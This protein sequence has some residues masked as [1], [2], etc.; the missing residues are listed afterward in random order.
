MNG[1]IQQ[2]LLKNFAYFSLL[3]PLHDVFI[4]QLLSRELEYVPLAHSCNIQ[5]PWCKKCP[6]CAYIWLNYM[7]YLPEKLVNQIFDN[8]NLL[9]LPENQLHFQQLLGFGSHSPF[10]CIGQVEESQLAL[11]RCYL[12]GVRGNAMKWY[13]ELYE[14]DFDQIV[15]KFT[16]VATHV[17]IPKK[18]ADI[19]YPYLFEI[20][21]ITQ[22]E[23]QTRIEI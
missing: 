8:V 23:L 11:H 21:Q 5:K 20:Q 9:D 7:A 6:K 14:V 13:H 17:G 10:E 1:Y 3:Q 22:F 12:K 19:L 15:E 4:F 18:Y 16:S 2:H